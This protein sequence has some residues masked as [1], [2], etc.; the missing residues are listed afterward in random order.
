MKKYIR[1]WVTLKRMTYKIR[2]VGSPLIKDYEK[3]LR[4]GSIEGTWKDFWE[5]EFWGNGSEKGY[6]RK[7]TGFRVTRW[8]TLFWGNLAFLR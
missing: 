2:S 1:I 3:E 5:L 4:I 7:H 6:T 8:K